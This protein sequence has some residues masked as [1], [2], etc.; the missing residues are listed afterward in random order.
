MNRHAYY[1]TNMMDIVTLTNDIKAFGKPFFWDF[2][3][4][5]YSAKD[6][7][8]TSEGYWEELGILIH[9]DLLRSWGIEYVDVWEGSTQTK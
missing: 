5:H 6:I 9:I 7:S 2:K 8:S 4:I 3:G 1:D